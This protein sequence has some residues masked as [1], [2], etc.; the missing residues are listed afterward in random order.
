MMLTGNWF[1]KTVD[2][3][4]RG[5][6]DEELSIVTAALNAARVGSAYSMQLEASG[7]GTWA[8]VDAPSFLGF[9]LSSSGLLSGPAPAAE[10]L[11]LLTVE[12]LSPSGRPTS[13]SFE[14]RIMPAAAPPPS[15]KPA[16]LTDVLPPGEVGVPYDQPIAYSYVTGGVVTIELD[17]LPAGLI[18]ADSGRR[19]QGTPGVPGTFSPGARPT[20]N[21]VDIGERRRMT[22]RI[23]GAV[24]PEGSSPWAPAIAGIHGG[25]R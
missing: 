23:T 13:K 12:V 15:D 5:Q 18:P 19:I 20:G 6:W 17:S 16:I 7:T 25:K 21:G 9:S 14:L 2:G 11:V 24:Q 1:E 22:L 4:H 8:L 10:D 3:D